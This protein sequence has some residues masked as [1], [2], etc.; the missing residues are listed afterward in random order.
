MPVCKAWLVSCN[1]PCHQQVILSPARRDMV[2]P[3]GSCYQTGR[4][5][6]FTEQWP[7]VFMESCF[8]GRGQGHA[9]MKAGREP[10]EG[11]DMG[12]RRMAGR[13]Q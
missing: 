3:C 11:P 6:A 1:S 4:L 2:G 13:L 12:V 9:G 8:L 7:P 5:L 10:R